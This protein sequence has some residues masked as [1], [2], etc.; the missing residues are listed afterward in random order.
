VTIIYTFRPAK[1]SPTVNYEWSVSLTLL[2]TD[3]PQRFVIPVVYHCAFLSFFL[4]LLKLKILLK[5]RRKTVAFQQASLLD[6]LFRIGRQIIEI[7]Q[8]RDAVS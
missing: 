8:Q 4:L 2:Y 1:K 5:H 6:N 3:H 7:I